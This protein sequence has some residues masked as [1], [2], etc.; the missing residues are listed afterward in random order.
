MNL[1]LLTYSPGNRL[2]YIKGDAR[3]HDDLRKAK[4]DTAAAC[5]I[6]ADRETN[7]NNHEDAIS[8]LRAMSIKT[9]DMKITM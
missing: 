2:T 1:L 3:S 5:F 8:V 9:F 4:A 7:D 6:L